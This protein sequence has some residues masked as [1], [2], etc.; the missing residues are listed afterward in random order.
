MKNRNITDQ[1]S[2]SIRDLKNYL[3]IR[4]ISP[5]IFAKEVQLSHMTIRRWLQ[6]NGHDH[7]PAKYHELLFPVLGQNPITSE[8]L[9]FNTE[10]LMDEI[11]KS[12]KNFK[13]VGKLDQ[14]VSE[15]LKSARVDRIFFDYCKRL[16]RAI[17]SPRTSLKSKAI[18]AGALI[19]F[20]S[21]IDLIPDHI[22]VVGYLDDL[23]VLSLAVN[24]LATEEPESKVERYRL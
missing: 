11:E 20:I 3:A 4:Q 5:E 6:K 15:K 8:N 22:P 19:Y 7:L 12:G 10:S 14:D 21:P 16:I 18:A 9:A 2:L 13:D 17:K 1:P 24:S 23:A